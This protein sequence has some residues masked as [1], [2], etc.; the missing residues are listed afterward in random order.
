MI[1]LGTI[2]NAAAVIA[3]G[4]VGSRVKNGLPRRYRD[5]IMQ[6]I[7]LSVVIIGVSGAL[8][9]IGSLKGSKPDPIMFMILSL[10]IGS[11]I[12]E[13]LNIEA[14]LDRLGKWFQRRFARGDNNFAQGFVSASL[15][16]CVGAMAIVGALDDGL[17]GDAGT[18]YAKSILDGV[19]A[20]VFATTLG[21]GVAFSA[22]TVLLYQGGITLLAGSIGPY[23]TIAV[24]DE[25]S[26]VGNV[27]IMA[28]GINLLH[29]KKIKVG[30]MLPAIFVPLVYD[31]IHNHV[32]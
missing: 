2:V 22:I 32:I 1:G 19:S 13:W 23:L 16:F 28:I 8:Q 15:L 21:I 25:M 14:R 5:I 18:L 12:G 11:A 30:N 27:L 3:G 20:T 17:N 6:A 4:I 26:L 9:G 29:I 7:G 24:R 10:V 31:L